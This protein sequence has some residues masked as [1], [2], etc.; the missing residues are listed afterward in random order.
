MTESQNTDIDLMK[1]VLQRTGDDCKVIIEGDYS[2][3]V[4]S[5]YYAGVNNGMK[6]ASEVFRGHNFYG[7]VTLPIIHRSK[8]AELAEKM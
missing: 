5:A 3:Q 2:T 1:L 7:E 4:D 6:R 8:I